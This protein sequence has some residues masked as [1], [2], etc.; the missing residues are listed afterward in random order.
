MKKIGT[1]SIPSPGMFSLR[2]RRIKKMIAWGKQH[3]AKDREADGYALEIY[4][5]PGEKPFR[6][7]RVPPHAPP[8]RCKKVQIS[9][10]ALM[11]ITAIVPFV[12]VTCMHIAY[13]LSCTSQYTVGLAVGLII[14]NVMCILPYISWFAFAGLFA[15]LVI[16]F[17]R[18]SRHPECAGQMQ[19]QESAF[20]ASAPLVPAG[21]LSSGGSDPTRL[22]SSSHLSSILDESSNLE[23]ASQAS[24]VL[25][26]DAA[27]TSSFDS[28]FSESSLNDF[29]PKWRSPL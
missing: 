24:T 17:V 26:E 4:R 29:T 18:R 27:T 25:Q 11:V 8:H 7:I 15:W 28:A 12:I 21:S 1:E 2:G 5:K 14:L 3:M 22:D 6:V 16:L 10:T 13:A 9:L 19:S 20:R 23:M